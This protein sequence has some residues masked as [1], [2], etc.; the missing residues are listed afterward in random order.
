MVERGEDRFFAMLGNQYRLV[1]DRD[2]V[3]RNG[4]GEYYTST[5]Q[6]TLEKIMPVL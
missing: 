2:D 3:R 5:N 6:L 1:L 4:Y